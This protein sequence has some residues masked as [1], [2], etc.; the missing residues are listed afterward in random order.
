MQ[1]GSEFSNQVILVTGPAG[2]LGSAVVK[3]FQSDGARMLLIDHRPD[4]LS[5]LYP[6]LAEKPEHLLIPGVDLRDNNQ[7]D[8]A[9]QLAIKTLGR[10]DC[11]VH[12]A[13]GFQMG[14]KVHE[15]SPES[16]DHLMDLNL[17]YGWSQACPGRKSSDGCV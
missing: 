15:I 10:I 16:W 8:S 11:L 3:K 1:K 6:Q 4:R 17:H 7:V 14:E 5:T 13:G 9:I 2:N 12:T